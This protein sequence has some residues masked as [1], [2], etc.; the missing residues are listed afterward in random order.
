MSTLYMVR[1]NFP[2]VQPASGATGAT[3][4]LQ[5]ENNSRLSGQTVG[6]IKINLT[7]GR[8]YKIPTTHCFSSGAPLSS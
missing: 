7:R 5:Q 6:F 1:V 4:Q 2:L 8:V 3:R